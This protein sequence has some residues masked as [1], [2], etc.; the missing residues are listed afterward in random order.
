MS[1]LDARTLG[2]DGQAIYARINACTNSDQLDGIMKLLWS[3]WYPSGVVTD[4]EAELLTEAVERRRPT[5]RRTPRVGGSVAAVGRLA[6]RMQRRFTPRKPQRSPNRKASRERRRMLGGSGCMPAKWARCT[7][8]ESGRRCVSSLARSSVKDCA[9]YR[10]T[11]L[12]RGPEFA[13]PPFRMPFMKHAGWA[14]SPSWNV[15][16]VG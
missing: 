8:R 12:P 3:E 13:E 9:S 16:G 5:S 10:S 1:A 7:P 11:K 4:R 6:E 14:T 2:W 15:P